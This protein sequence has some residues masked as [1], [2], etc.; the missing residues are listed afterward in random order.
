MVMNDETT[1]A[2]CGGTGWKTVERDGISAVERCE[3]AV[4]ERARDLEES[5]GIP[6]LYQDAS[7]ESFNRYVDNPAAKPLLDQAVNIARGYVREYPALEGK[8]GLLF[9]GDPGTGKTHLAVA[10]LRR[11][12]DRGFQCVFFSYQQL[13]DKIRSGYDRASGA[14]D[15]E[16]YRTALECEVLLLDDL[17][18]HRVKDWVED[19]ITSIVSHRCN[20][21]KALIATT[22]LRDESVDGTMPDGLPEQAATGRYLS[23]QIG[24][25][26]RSRLMEMCQVIKTRGVPDYRLRVR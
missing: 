22:N 20:Q 23:E 26:A 12:L 10:V 17:G 21:K 14:S 19:T 4:S 3:C 2:I 1:C 13:L 8:R 16:A 6:P 18:A 24:V 15:R 11:L 5:A 7:F 25:R 9:I